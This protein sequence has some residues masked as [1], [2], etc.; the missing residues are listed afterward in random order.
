MTNHPDIAHFISGR[1]RL[2]MG[3]HRSYAKAAAI[4]NLV[5]IVAVESDAEALRFFKF[6]VINLGL[7]M[8]MR[9]VT[10]PATGFVEN[11]TENQI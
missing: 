1:R 4:L 7:R 2:L 9:R 3:V 8:I 10:R 6:I 11:L 5:A